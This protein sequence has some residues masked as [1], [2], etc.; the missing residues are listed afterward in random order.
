VSAVKNRKQKNETD[1]FLYI[2][3]CYRY[4]PFISNPQNKRKHIN[5]SKPSTTQLNPKHS[6]IC[7]HS[8]F[9]SYALYNKQRLLPYTTSTVWTS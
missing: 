9:I 7:P 4:D 6:E 1:I 2:I 5:H 8:A 3:R